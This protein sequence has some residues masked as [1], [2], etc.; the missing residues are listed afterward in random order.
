MN[1]GQQ[2]CAALLL[3]GS[4]KGERDEVALQTGVACKAL[5]PVGGQAMVERVATILKAHPKITSITV[6]LADSL[7]LIQTAPKLAQWLAEGTLTRVDPHESLVDSVTT[8]LKGLP[9]NSFG[10]ITTADHVLLSPS[11]LDRMLEWSAENNEVPDIVVGMLPLNV[12]AAKYPTM[13]RTRMRFSDGAYKGC[14]LFLMRNNAAVVKALEFWRAMVALRKTPL[15]IAR[16]VGPGVLLRYLLGALS[17]QQGFTYLS[18]KTG[19][20]ITPRLLE[21]PEAG[22]DVDTPADLLFVENILRRS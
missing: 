7:P 14:N 11:M 10:L 17:L 2:T 4:R 3:A 16:R 6:S 9:V 13:K 20:R 21:I 15:R 12:L 1:S 18:N 8:W 19:A 22:I 5:A